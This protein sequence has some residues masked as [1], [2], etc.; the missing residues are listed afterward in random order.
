MFL[1]FN[2]LARKFHDELHVE[3][4]KFVQKGSWRG[5][6][7]FRYGDMFHVWLTKKFFGVQLTLDDFV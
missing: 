7:M 6:P 2:P 1:K 3:V 5:V 4:M